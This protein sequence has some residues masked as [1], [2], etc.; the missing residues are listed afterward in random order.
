M[1]RSLG[2]DTYVGPVPGGGVDM[3]P[4]GDSCSGITLVRNALVAR[5]MADTIIMAGAPGGVRDFGKDVR[6]WVGSPV[7]DGTP[8][9]RA[10]ELAAVYAR[11]PRV[12]P[13]SISVN[14][15]TA[16]AGGQYEFLIAV[17]CRT[18]SG[19][20]IAMVMGV[21]AI[22]VDILAQQGASP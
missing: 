7:D 21:N 22:S 1:D 19:Q 4:G 13:G 11:D 16:Q 14:V 3:L 17:T 12:D 18:V 2:Y 8:A 20:A 10:R 6:A 15:G 5:S 9:A